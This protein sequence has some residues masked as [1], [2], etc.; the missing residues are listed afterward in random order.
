MC[1]LL[2]AISATLNQKEFNRRFAI[3]NARNVA[4]LA[5]GDL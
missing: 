1:F 2:H 4:P 5:N 3:S